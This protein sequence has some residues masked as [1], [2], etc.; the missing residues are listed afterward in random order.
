MI[1]RITMHEMIAD[2]T[3]ER[4]TVEQRQMITVTTASDTVKRDLELLGKRK[5]SAVP[6]S[7]GPL[8][9][10]VLSRRADPWALRS[11]RPQSYSV[12][13]ASTGLT[14][15][16]RWAGKRQAMSAANPRIVRVALSRS[17]LYSEI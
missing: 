8:F 3:G 6:A 9:F 12:R 13:S 5:G 1:P 16:A 15:V 11:N 2:A 14:S 10:F 7:L 17:G 4:A